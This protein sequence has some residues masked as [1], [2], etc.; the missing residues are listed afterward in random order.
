MKKQSFFSKLFK[1]QDEVP[2]EPGYEKIPTLMES[3][4]QDEKPEEVGDMPPM[5]IPVPE[6]DEKEII[7][8]IDVYVNK[9]KVATHAIE[10]PTRIG[11]DPARADI[12]IPEL[13]VSKLHCTLYAKDGSIYVRDNT[14]TNGTY[15]D[16]R[17]I[18][19]QGITDNTVIGLGKKGTVQII[20]HKGVPK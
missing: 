17:K 6:F 8:E 10:S 3:P 15:V 9:G 11:R 5:D 16:N 1:K 20:F 19:Q 18:Y 12:V 7:G 2:E 14:S 13:I 4:R